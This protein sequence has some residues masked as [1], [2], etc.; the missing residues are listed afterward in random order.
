MNEWMTGAE[1]LEWM[2]EWMIAELVITEWM[3][4]HRINDKSNGRMSERMN[5]WQ[6]QRG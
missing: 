4:V 3:I 6:V 2:R 1:M 5:E